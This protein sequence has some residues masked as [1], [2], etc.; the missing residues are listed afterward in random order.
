M[1]RATR[2]VL[3]ITWADSKYHRFQFDVR[4]FYQ[5]QGFDGKG[6]SGARV[7]TKAR[8]CGVPR[9]RVRRACVSGRVELGWG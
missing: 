5:N 1:S 9:V 3:Q 8:V 7:E 6:Q 2:R 4:A